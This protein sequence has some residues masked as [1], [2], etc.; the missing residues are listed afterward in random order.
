MGKRSHLGMLAVFFCTFLYLFF[1]AAF[2]LAAVPE[3][4]GNLKAISGNKEASLTWNRV[5][6]AQGYIIYR[7]QDAAG[8]F[9]FVGQ[10][11]INCFADQKLSNGSDYYYVVTSF[12]TSGQSGY[13]Q[14]VHASPI[15]TALPAPD[16]IKTYSGNGEVSISWDG[17]VSAVHYTVYRISQ[18]GTITK[19]SPS[20]TSLSFTDRAVT[21]GQ[22]YHYV[23]Q[24]MSTNPGA[25]SYSV[26]ATPSAPLPKA[27]PTLTGSSG[28]TWGSLSWSASSGATRYTIQRSTSPGGPYSFRGTTEN[29]TFSETGLTNGTTYYYVITAS[30]NN[31]SSAFSPETTIIPSLTQKPLPATIWGWTKDEGAYVDWGGVPNAVSYDVYRRTKNKV[32]DEY[33]SSAVHLGNVT[34]TS[35]NDTDPPLNNST[36]YCYTVKSNNASSVKSTSNE[37]CFDPTEQLDPPSG[38]AIY[39]GNTKATITWEKVPGAYSYHIQRATS[40]GG[41]FITAGSA[42]RE[43]ESFTETGLTNG[44]P[45][46]FRIKSVLSGTSTTNYS[47]TIMAT[48]SASRPLNSTSLSGEQG[49]RQNSVRWES[50]PGATSYQVYRRIA[51]E[52]WQALTHPQLTSTSFNDTG[53]IN[54][55]TYY[56]NVAAKIG[57]LLGAWSGGPE[58]LTPSEEKSLA[59]TSITAVP[60]NTQIS[61][62]WK[63]VSTITDYFLELALTPG[64]PRHKYGYTTREKNSYTFTGLTNGMNYYVRVRTNSPGSMYSPEIHVVPQ[65]SLPLAPGG[66][67]TTEGNREVSLLWDTVPGATS[68][69]IY[70]RSEINDHGTV[71]IGTSDRSFFK[72]SAIDNGSQYHYSVSAVNN[73]GEGPRTSNERDA[74]PED[75]RMASPTQLSSLRGNTQLTVTWKPVLG[76]E[77]YYVTL[78][79]SP[80]GPYF[81]GGTST[82]GR[83]S[84]T[85]TDLTNTQPYFARVRTS[86]PASSADSG[87]VA[88]TPSVLAP[89]AP[90]SLT[91]KASGNREATIRWVNV[92]D[93]L[94][95]TIYRREES[96]FSAAK[97]IASSPSSLFT[98]SG[99]KNGTK[100]YYGVAVKN[101]FSDGPISV[102]ETS[103]TPHSDAPFAPTGVS[104]IPG[105]TQ[106]IL[107]W[108]GVAGATSYRI[109]QSSISGGYA[110]RTY[111]AESTSHTVEDLTNGT[112]YYFSIQAVN[113]ANE[114]SAHSQ[115]LF[116][117][118]LAQIL[119]SDMDGIGD[120]WEMSFF[121][122]LKV[123]DATS[124]YDKDHYSDLNE[125]LNWKK[126]ILDPAAKQFNPRYINAPGGAGYGKTGPGLGILRMIVP[127]LQ[128]RR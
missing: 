33:T 49:N 127:V 13:S 86:S 10:T 65:T 16:D 128:N 35:Y 96:S 62:S 103:C 82:Y 58:D 81:K 106:V 117:M 118:P 120:N 47:S 34:N 114:Y 60:G 8:P 36:R 100:Y 90:E 84:Y 121:G 72:D 76:G 30:N 88:T 113:E 91:C 107:T 99:L 105:S 53:L 1:L 40:P 97:I 19:L 20:T 125:Y 111:T 95:Y 32:T 87:E 78:A 21:N 98:D 93:A 15:L 104:A 63:P 89:L 109:H 59:P 52:A 77:R 80:G 124:D 64:G 41:P 85:F 25:Y 110:N 22:K 54:G 74:T 11:V 28:D 46:Y 12:N 83:T 50:V 70:R 42:N 57:N 43:K 126:N 45:Y 56:Y 48:P 122:S 27:P 68:Y 71:L 69:T 101:G 119:D 112:L 6:G 38:I 5:A 2:S 51:D 31:G 67:S 66:L 29:L 79:T 61:L 9:A 94:S 26:A 115:E 55:V 23:V 4:P 18:S 37:I 92:D 17:V 108:N 44:Q 75:S 39:P 123:C 3:K 102:Q 73:H 14:V 7:S 24:T 116:V